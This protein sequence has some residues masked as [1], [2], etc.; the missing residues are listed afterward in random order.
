MEKVKIKLKSIKGNNRLSF[1][2]ALKE[3]S[4]LGLKDAKEIC[5][6]MTFGNKG[7][8]SGVEQE[9]E[10]S[11]PQQLK[12]DCLEF[13]Y[14]LEINDKY[15][16]RK[17]LFFDM[18]IC[19]EEEII[20]NLVDMITDGLDLYLPASCPDEIHGRNHKLIKEHISGKLKD[21][22]TE[23]LKLLNNDLLK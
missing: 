3:Y 7:I 22:D 17:K 18:G 14:E 10:L 11:D 1:V 21:L 12:K 2:K 15:L 16:K 19:T 13:G 5:D 6:Q 4:G 9:L 23:T 20:D 8:P